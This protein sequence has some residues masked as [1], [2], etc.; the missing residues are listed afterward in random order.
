MKFIITIA[1]GYI[2]FKL[3]FGTKSLE[4]G[5]EYDQETDDG[6]YAEYEEVD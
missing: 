3:F 5:K 4:E 2:L 1:V 6:E